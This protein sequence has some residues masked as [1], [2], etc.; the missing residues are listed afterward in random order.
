MTSALQWKRS[1]EGLYWCAAEPGFQP[2]FH[3]LR[4]WGWLEEDKT[5]RVVHPET[6]CRPKRIQIA[7]TIPPLEVLNRLQGK[8]C[9]FSKLVHKDITRLWMKYLSL[10]LKTTL[11]ITPLPM[12]ATLKKQIFLK[13][14]QLL[15]LKAPVNST[16]W[17]FTSFYFI[18]DIRTFHKNNKV[19]ATFG[20][21]FTLSDDHLWS[22]VRATFIGQS[23]GSIELLPFIGF[24]PSSFN[25]LHGFSVCSRGWMTMVRV[26][27]KAKQKRSWAANLQTTS[28]DFNLGAKPEAH[29]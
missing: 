11:C 5:L 7:S 28:D 16:S 29:K 10:K 15:R 24:R 2:N 17:Y 27:L 4:V 26:H 9:R 1:A 21:G 19:S 6:H 8:L 23:L 20:E 3:Q 18:E 12:W 13:T 22:R 25:T 14:W